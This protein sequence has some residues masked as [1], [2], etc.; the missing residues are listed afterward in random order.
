VLA[1]ETLDIATRHGFPLWQ[2]GAL[3]S[4]GWAL[5][6][7]KDPGGVAVLQQCVQATRAA[8]GGVTLMVLEP[9][10]DAHLLLGQF[11][12][13]LD[14]H[15]QA[16]EVS[17]ALGDHHIDAELHRLRG[18]CWWRSTN[19]NALEVQA[20]F[21]EALRVSQR[22][23]AKSLELRAATSLARLLQSQGQPDAAQQVLQA[24]DPWFSEGLDTPDSQDARALLTQ[25]SRG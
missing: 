1:Q 16:S 13:A 23:Q 24:I 20:C 2:V 9:L 17:A 22:Q 8:M 18:E 6:M 12:A 21:E 5:A 10:V 15:T 3:L 25:L 7:Q 14:V 19:P 4:R 11:E